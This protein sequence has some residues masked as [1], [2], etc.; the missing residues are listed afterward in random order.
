M[1]K[2]VNGD[3]PAD[4]SDALAVTV[5]LGQAPVNLLR[6]VQ[7]SMY[8]CGQD[9]DG[10]YRWQTLTVAEANDAVAGRYPNAAN[11]DTNVLAQLVF[12]SWYAGR[13]RVMSIN[14]KP[15]SGVGQFLVE[16]SAAHSTYDGG[17]L[18]IKAPINARST[19]M[20]NYTVS[21][22]E[23]DDS[24]T[25][26]YS[27]VTAVNPFSLQQERANSLVDARQIFNLN[28]IFN[29]PAGFKANPLFVTRSGLPYTPIIGFDTQND[30]NDLNDRATVNGTVAG[31]NSM[32]QP[33]FSSLDLRLVKDFT[34]KGEGHHLD[35]FM[36]IFNIVGADDMVHPEFAGGPPTMFIA[37][38][39][40]GAKT[41][42]REILT[43]FG[44]DSAD[45]GGIT[46]ARYLEAMC[47][48]WLLYGQ[49]TGKWHHAFKMLT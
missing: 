45:I 17:F 14:G 43:T 41:A 46:S 25:S 47:M 19:L 4:R 33:A 31:R 12:N 28:A 1:V 48:T 34:L 20:A 11:S 2:V 9:T 49:S 6:R 3:D 16:Q 29:L 40:A 37:G 18:T 38:D 13:T 23:D 36:D 27:P 32:R 39:D 5:L 8:G 24:S 22:T 30:A 35:L 15:I 42:V 21:R 44:W 10:E 7:Q 26:P